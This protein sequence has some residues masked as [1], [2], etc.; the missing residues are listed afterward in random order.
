MRDPVALARLAYSNV[1]RSSRF[2]NNQNPLRSHAK[3]FTRSRR[4]LRNTKKCPENGS[5]WNESRTMAC[6]PSKALR[7]S[8]ESRARKTRTDDGKLSM[9]TTP[10]SVGEERRRRSRGRHELLLPKGD[11]CRT[12]PIAGG[13]VMRSHLLERS[14]SG[15]HRARASAPTRRSSVAPRSGALSAVAPS[16]GVAIPAPR[17]SQRAHASS[18]DRALAAPG[19]DRSR[20]RFAT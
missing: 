20:R 12:H 15:I 16:T 1:P 7:K 19:F 9:T 3:I 5:S 13:S 11:R 14:L 17:Q 10:R 18:G 8:T 4:R 2:A 6:R